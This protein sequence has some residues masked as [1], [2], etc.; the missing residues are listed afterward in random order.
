MG[1]GSVFTSKAG[2]LE[3]KKRQK[4]EESVLKRSGKA[5]TNE[6]PFPIYQIDIK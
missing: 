6:S 2:T 4:F 3:K 5:Y 1:C